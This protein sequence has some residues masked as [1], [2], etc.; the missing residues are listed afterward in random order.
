MEMKFPA[1]VEVVHDDDVEIKDPLKVTS[2]MR[3]SLVRGSVNS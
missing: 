2:W 3:S 1:M